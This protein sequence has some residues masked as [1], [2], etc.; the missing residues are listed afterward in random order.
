M[1]GWI[2]L[3]SPKAS[4]RRIMARHSKLGAVS[5]GSCRRRWAAH[6]LHSQDDGVG[7]DGRDDEDLRHATVS[8][9][10]KASRL[11]A[12]GGATNRWWWAIAILTSSQC[13]EEMRWQA[14]FSP[15]VVGCR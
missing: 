13:D 8:D 7:Q 3:Q 5:A 2:N 6:H 14:P 4:V 9:R 10:Q 12:T 15:S 1:N 11:Q